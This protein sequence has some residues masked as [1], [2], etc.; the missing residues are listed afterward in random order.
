MTFLYSERFLEKSNDIL[1]RIPGKNEYRIS[2]GKIRLMILS[3]EFMNIRSPLGYVG[4]SACE[5]AHTN[6]KCCF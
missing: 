1:F 2:G 3:A 5:L 6:T 4:G